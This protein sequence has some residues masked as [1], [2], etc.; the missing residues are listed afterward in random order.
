M[1][2]T[3]PFTLG[4][5]RINGYITNYYKKLHFKLRCHFMDLKSNCYYVF[6]SCFN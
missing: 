3:K 4:G 6:L 1:I 5:G 2:F